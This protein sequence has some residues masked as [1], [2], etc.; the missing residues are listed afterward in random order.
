MENARYLRMVIFIETQVEMHSTIQKFK[1]R[2]RQSNITYI[3]I[4]KDTSMDWNEIL[5]KLPKE[6]WKRIEYPIMVEK[7][8]IER[9]RR[10]LHQAQGILCTIEPL[11]SLLGLDSRTTF[12]NCVLG[13]IVNLSQLPLTKL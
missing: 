6:E 2:N 12:G 1:T 4:S 3:D 13:G 9:N 5:K 10:H 7:Y 11:H 8:I